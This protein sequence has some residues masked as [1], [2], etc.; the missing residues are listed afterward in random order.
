MPKH[1]D[2][3]NR[4]Q[5]RNRFK[6]SE[7]SPCQPLLANQLFCVLPSSNIMGEERKLE[8]SSRSGKKG[9][10]QWNHSGRPSGWLA[11]IPAEH[12]CLSNA[13][14]ILIAN[15]ELEVE[16]SPKRISNLRISNRKFM[17]IFQS[18]NWAASEF[19]RLQPTNSTSLARASS[20]A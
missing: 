17:T 18:E 14:Q 8:R 19:R 12:G 4:F 5:G 20:H 9:A 13:L 7:N 11:T 6:A 15:L 2:R 3:V 10:C 1:P 16:L